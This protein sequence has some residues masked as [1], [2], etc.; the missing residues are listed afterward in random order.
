MS[1]F[2]FLS[3]LS[4]ES[5]RSIV[6]TS[7]SHST[8]VALIS[9]AVLAGQSSV[10][11]AT[12]PVEQCDGSS[13]ALRVISDVQGDVSNQAND[14]SPL[15][16]Q[17]V[18]VEAIV[19]LDGQPGLLAN[20]EA[21][22][23]YNGFWI[24]EEA[25]DQDSLGSTSEGVFVRST[26][27]DVS[28]GD[29]VRVAGTVSELDGVTFIH[30]VTSIGI[31]ASGLDLPAATKLHL[32]VSAASDLEALEGMRI[33]NQQGL[34]V[35]DFYGAGYGFGNDG[36]L[37]ASSMLH[38]QPTDLARPGSA[39]AQ[40]T[41]ADYVL[42]RLLVDDGVAANY[43]SFIPFPDSN[44]YSVDNPIRV[45]DSFTTLSGVLHQIDD[46][47]VVVP[48]KYLIDQTHPR[49][50]A[51]VV[52]DQANLIIASMNVLNYFNGD[53]QGGGFPTARGARTAAAFE[54]QSDKVVAAIAA[55][56]ADILG[57]ME[58]E[59]DGFGVQSA[60]QQLL[61]DVNSQQ[62][63]GDD[64]QFVAVDSGLLGTDAIRVGLFY[65]PARVSP[66]GSTQVLNSDH[67]PTD[68]DGV[69]FDDQ[70]HRPAM[71]QSF[72]VSDTVITVAV[73]HLKSKGSRCNELN[74]GDDGQGN[75]NQARTRAAEGLIQ[76]LASNPTGVDSEAVLV[77]GD[78]NAYSQ[79]DPVI[80][81][82][83]AGYTNLKH[84][85]MA[86]EERP[87]SYRFSGRLGSLDHALATSDLAQY[88]V[89]AGAWHINSVE[90]A[91]M[92]YQTE[93]T[94]QNDSSVDTYAAADAYRSS[95][96][97]PVVVGLRIPEATNQSPVV[98]QPLADIVISSVDQDVSVDVS[99]SFSDPDDD[100]LSLSATGL[101]SDWVMSSAGVLS[102]I[103]TQSVL[104]GWPT[105]NA[106]DVVVMA[107]DGEF[108]AQASLTLMN[109]VIA[110]SDGGDND[111]ADSGSE[112]AG[113][114]V[115][116]VWLLM[117][118]GVAGV[119]RRTRR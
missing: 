111:A 35:A 63:P 75:C 78:L 72:R 27:V 92:D 34:V 81:F 29:R 46:D 86:T 101:P 42:D 48:A 65:R 96:H 97:D 32:P 56:D 85:D 102:G 6:Y 107:S 83:Q 113:G 40:H 38:F 67:S 50:M 112:S 53:G 103:A 100:V 16:G 8:T 1:K 51:P 114:A 87:Y 45:G 79:E 28:E 84:S 10:A 80:A 90:D 118:A 117:M 20:G 91:L 57:L 59:N 66:V 99:G 95:D 54:M 89:S 88:V 55:L 31:C 12:V 19:T 13:A 7:L 2:S 30:E 26:L 108:T 5:F 98:V 77:M 43:P 14:A 37:V 106:V 33:Q 105:S 22:S 3:R 21:S 18:V 61:D 17:L 23:R 60:I 93:G 49:T 71:V 119:F 36:Q 24:Q 76:Y 52:D 82:E 58:L 110:N 11:V 41:S 39:L 25:V 69:L 62:A 104:D 64:Y 74:E 109:A 116:A 94:G 44:G 73:N 15:F 4:P 115:G 68:N 70:R 47:Y 9:A